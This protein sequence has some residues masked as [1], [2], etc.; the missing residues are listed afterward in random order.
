MK[1]LSDP[2][3]LQESVKRDLYQWNER[4]RDP[5][6]RPRSEL[7]VKGKIA[8]W[9]LASCHV[10]V[11]LWQLS[12]GLMNLS[13]SVLWLFLV[14]IDNLARFSRQLLLQV[15]LQWDVSCTERANIASFIIVFMIKARLLLA[16]SAPEIMQFKFLNFFITYC[17]MICYD[18]HHPSVKSSQYRTDV[19]EFCERG[20]ILHRHGILWG[21]PAQIICP[22]KIIFI[23]VFFQHTSD[24]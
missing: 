12:H 7:A 9:S 1:D 14:S 23:L 19:R 2:N 16:V 13:L 22:E 11:M 24:E 10:V 4:A 15:V 5:I 20:I 3:S 18:W 6:C 17:R 21:K 8:A